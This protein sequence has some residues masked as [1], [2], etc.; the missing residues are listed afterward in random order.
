M[1]SNNEVEIQTSRFIEKLLPLNNRVY[2]F[3]GEELL[4]QNVLT[5]L[6]PFIN[7]R[8]GV[9]KLIENMSE[10]ITLENND[11]R[12]SLKSFVNGL[13]YNRTRIKQFPYD[14]TELNSL[15]IPSNLRGVI[16][17]LEFFLE[18]EDPNDVLNSNQKIK[19]ENTIR[20]TYFEENNPNISSLHV[21]S[22]K[23]F[24]IK[25]NIIKYKSYLM[26]Q[27]NESLTHNHIYFLE[28][29]SE[30]PINVKNY[31]ALNYFLDLVNSDDFIMKLNDESNAE[32]LRLKSKM[33]NNITLGDV[34]QSIEFLKE[35]TK[36]IEVHRLI[37]ALKQFYSIEL[38]YNYFNFALLDLLPKK[39]LAIS[40]IKD[41]HR[42]IDN[43]TKLIMRSFIPDTHEVYESQQESDFQFKNL[44][45]EP[46]NNNAYDRTF[47]RKRYVDSYKEEPEKTSD[48]ELEMLYKLTEKVSFLKVASRGHVYRSANGFESGRLNS[49]K[50]R[51]IYYF[52]ENVHHEMK[53]NYFY[54]AN[55]F[56]YFTNEKYIIESTKADSYIFLSLF[57]IDLFYR[58][59]YYRAKDE[60]FK[61]L[62]TSINRFFTNSN[63]KSKSFFN[64][65]WTGF[66]FNENEF[67]PPFSLEDIQVS[68][69][70]E[71]LMILNQNTKSVNPKDNIKKDKKFEE[72]SFP[73]QMDILEL[74][75]NESEFA[76]N[77]EYN[78]T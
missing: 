58:K 7:D 35:L 37:Y 34:W 54:L 2:L 14:K 57:D 67:V 51:D 64:N 53:S 50:Y 71:N 75:F 31:F 26:S 46:S 33:S 55:P 17:M 78:E 1:I 65:H 49:F 13:V 52:G 39:E 16:F 48:E 23:A 30:R 8:Q 12:N 18:M 22:L 70:F 42:Y 5:I 4:K 29:W 59:N 44:T 69:L 61:Y 56:T 27:I 11:D 72:Y 38:I 24:I 9:I 73:E 47:F 21:N 66:L 3:S 77:S 15:V 20:Q 68:V 19:I 36:D 40:I 62:L 60:R 76:N 45:Y 10:Q 74:F 25:E 28:E 32:I 43:Y 63:D 6:D 41:K